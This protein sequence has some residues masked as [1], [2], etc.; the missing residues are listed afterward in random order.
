MIV[1]IHTSH[2]DKAINGQSFSA[3]YIRLFVQWI[4][5]IRVRV[6]MVGFVPVVAQIFAKAT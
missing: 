5:A 4:T 1:A 6:K 3:G 2:N